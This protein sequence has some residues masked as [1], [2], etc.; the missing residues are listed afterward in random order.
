MTVIG[1]AERFMQQ[2][3]GPVTISNHNNKHGGHSG[4]VVTSGL[5]VSTSVECVVCRDKSSGKHYGQLTCE[6]C[7]SFFKRSVRRNLS[8]AC[9]VARDC[10]VD[11]QHRN[12]CQ[13]CRFKKCIKAGMKPEG[14]AFVNITEAYIAE[15][16]SQSP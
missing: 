16:Y 5:A 1:R 9:R 10:P 12:Q 4:E 7:K 11:L 2:V 3:P 13:F 6:G 15:H 14:E 8:Y